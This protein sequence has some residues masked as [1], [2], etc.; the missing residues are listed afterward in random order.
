MKKIKNYIVGLFDSKSG[1]SNLT[2]Y[3]IYAVLIVIIILLLK[4]CQKERN[5]RK[6]MEKVGRLKDQSIKYWKDE[7]GKEHATVE[8]IKASKKVIEYYFQ[9]KMDSI[10]KILKIKEKQIQDFN[11]IKFIASGS[12]K[13]KV[14]TRDSI[15]Y[16]RDPNDYGVYVPKDTI[17]SQIHP[18]DGYLAFNA[19]MKKNGTYDYDYTYKDELTRVTHYEKFGFLN[20][21]KRSIIDFSFKNP[22]SHI[23]GIT[24]FRVEPDKIKRFGIGPFIGYGW[25]GKK[26]GITGGIALQ[27]NFIRF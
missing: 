13:G 14:I 23:S 17:T 18:N 16:V 26:F 9:E 15:V 19:Y 20:L 4:Q 24:Q 2:K 7:N 5:E 11:E 12:G 3:L 21:K 8:E 25:T 27:Y 22:K 10:S 6:D 1:N